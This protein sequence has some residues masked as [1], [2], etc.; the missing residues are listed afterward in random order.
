MAAA[1][2]IPNAACHDRS[3]AGLSG[4]HIHSDLV[5]RKAEDRDGVKRILAASGL[6][7]DRK[8]RQQVKM[9]AFVIE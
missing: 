3:A 6:S 5:E 8:C 9:S 7:S 4:A 2:M 1:A